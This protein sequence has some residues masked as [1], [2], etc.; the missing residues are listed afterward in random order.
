MRVRNQSTI[1]ALETRRLL[2]GATLGADG[3]L[4]VLSDDL[5]TNAITVSNSLDGL[6][7]DVTINS[8][9]SLGVVKTFSRSFLKSAG[10]SSLWVTGGSK[11]DT[12]TA[13]DTN[14][15]F[16]LAMRVD[17]RGGSDTINTGDGNDLV[18]AGG[19]NDIVNANDGNDRV[20]GGLGNDDLDAG[21]DNDRVSGG[22]G[23]DTIELGGG[24]DFARGDAGNDVIDGH[25]GNDL[26][27]GCGGDDI[28]SGEKDNDTL[29]GGGGTDRLMGGDDDDT[30]GGVLGTNVMLG[31]DG[32]DI[33][34]VLSQTQNPSNDLVSPPDTWQVVTGTN[35]GGTVPAV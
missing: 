12:I 24:D 25:N 9:N 15:A 30:L 14:S 23:N 17:G 35:E 11:N 6:S 22:W 19:G 27:Y 2:A 29:W 20:F 28:L 10:I 31:E 33:F 8:T 32:S 34:V 13:D 7:V 5:K 18:Y 26:I 3:V 1:E 21:G 16:T 4:R